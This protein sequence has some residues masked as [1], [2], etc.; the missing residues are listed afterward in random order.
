MN[1]DKQDEMLLVALQLYEKEQPQGVPLDAR[2]ESM[3]S[4]IFI[5]RCHN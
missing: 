1:C 4:E 2:Y 3:L 5:P